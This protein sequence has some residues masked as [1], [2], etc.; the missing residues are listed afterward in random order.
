MLNRYYAIGL[1][2][3]FLVLSSNAGIIE[4]GAIDTPGEAGDVVVDYDLYERFE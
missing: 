3:L 2:V 1:S 4:I